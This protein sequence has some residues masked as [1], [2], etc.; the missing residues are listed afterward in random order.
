MGKRKE[1]GQTENI[2]Y[3]MDDDENL[4]MDRAHTLRIDDMGPAL[5]YLRS[6]R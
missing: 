1:I 3:T 5:V 6:S 2:N 4:G